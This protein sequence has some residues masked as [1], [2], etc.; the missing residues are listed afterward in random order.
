M[1]KKCSLHKYGK[2]ILSQI[3]TK[4]CTKTLDSLYPYLNTEVRTFLEDGVSACT[5]KEFL[6]RLSTSLLATLVGTGV[7]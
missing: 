2:A 1:K 3:A 6:H 5:G 4:S 7:T